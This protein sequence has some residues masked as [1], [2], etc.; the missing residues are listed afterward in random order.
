MRWVLDN[1]Q[2]IGEAASSHL[3]LALP[4]IVASFLLALPL[5]CVPSDLTPA[6]AAEQE[7]IT[8]L[9]CEQEGR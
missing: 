9:E 1:L 3:G 6:T 4:A 7:C 2:L 5:G 8:D